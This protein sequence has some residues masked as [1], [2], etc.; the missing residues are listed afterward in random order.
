M[1]FPRHRQ[2]LIKSFGEARESK[3]VPPFGKDVFIYLGG[4]EGVQVCDLLGNYHRL[5][6]VYT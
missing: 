5:H 2:T 6:L 3:L 4:G 1:L